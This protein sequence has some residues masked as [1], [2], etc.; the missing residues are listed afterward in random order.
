MPTWK[1]GDESQGGTY[2]TRVL[3]YGGWFGSGNVGDDAILIG[4]RNLLSE[5]IPGV[6][7]ADQ[8][9]SA[10]AAI[11]RVTATGHLN[12]AVESF[13]RGVARPSLS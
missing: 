4:L 2:L 1:A 6:E 8:T 12:P 9:F 10:G 11:V 3:V 7:I 5:T 13:R